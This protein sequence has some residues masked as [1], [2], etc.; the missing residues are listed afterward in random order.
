MEVLGT[1]PAASRKAVRCVAREENVELRHELHNSAKEGKKSKSATI[2]HSGQATVSAR[3][4]DLGR[5]PQNATS[6]TSYPRVQ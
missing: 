3:R 4:E 1:Q 2:A 6:L 5:R